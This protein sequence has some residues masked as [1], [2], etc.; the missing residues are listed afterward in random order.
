MNIFWATEITPALEKV[1]DRF[2]TGGH[3]VEKIAIRVRVVK[4]CQFFRTS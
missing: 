1:E 4:L 3:P 2:K